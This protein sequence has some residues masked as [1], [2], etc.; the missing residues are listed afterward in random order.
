[1]NEL[2]Y[3]SNQDANSAQGFRTILVTEPSHPYISNWWPPG[4]IIG[5]EHSFVHAMADFLIALDK[6]EEIR[7]N[8]GDGV[9]ILA[10][11]EA[12]LESARTGKR[13]DVT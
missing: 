1:M 13:I 12:G 9:K 2:Q 4:H 10:V 3:F 7:P 11:L 6:K 8:F 5:Y